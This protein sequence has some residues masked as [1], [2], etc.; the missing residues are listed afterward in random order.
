MASVFPVLALFAVLLAIFLRNRLPFKIAPWQAMVA[1]ALFTL[2]FGFIS[3]QEAL[4][5]IDIGTM[6]FLYSTFVLASILQESG[7]LQHLGY[8][9]MSK[10]YQHPFLVL[11]AFVFC[12]GAASAFLLN[13][14]EAI[15]GVPLCIQLAKRSNVPTAPLLVALAIAVTVG[16]I[17]SPI[18]SPHNYIIATHGKMLSPFADFARYLLL[19]TIL[20]L[21]AVAAI[22]WLMFPDIRRLRTFSSDYW[23]R[24]KDYKAA[25]RGFQVVVALSFLRLLSGFVTGIPSFDLFLIP[26]AGAAVAVGLSSAPKKALDTDWETLAFFAGMFVLMAAVWQSGFF[27]S[28]LPS[29]SELGK[30]EVVLLSSLI[31]SQ[32]LSNVPFVILYIKALSAPIAAQTLAYLAAGSTLAGAITIIGAASNI[33]IMQASEKKGEKFPMKEF[34]IA[35]IASTLVSLALIVAWMSFI[36]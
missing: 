15:I 32:V 25:R 11:L 3:G 4:S 17:P 27:Q 18:G 19:P 12:A 8:K 31:L 7:Y 20:S 24:E 36:G 13:D 10:F 1:G 28:F 9:F 30:P 22:I 26:A 6:A 23:K 16:G 2:L 35:G 33:I 21:F 29:A 5:S 14:T 34:M